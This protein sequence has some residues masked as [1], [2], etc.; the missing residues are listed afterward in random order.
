MKNAQITKFNC[1]L[2]SICMG[3]LGEIGWYVKLETIAGKQTVK[4]NRD[5]D[6]IKQPLFQFRFEDRTG[7]FVREIK[8]KTSDENASKNPLFQNGEMRFTN[9]KAYQEDLEEEDK[10]LSSEEEE[11]KVENQEQ[12]KDESP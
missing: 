9:A 3:E 2:N 10:D 4:R 8:E 6:I 12:K 7:K 1:H 5:R 11:K